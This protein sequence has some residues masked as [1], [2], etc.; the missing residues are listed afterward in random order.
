MSA[1]LGGFQFLK[2]VHQLLVSQCSSGSHQRTCLQLCSPALLEGVLFTED[3]LENTQSMDSWRSH[4]PPQRASGL[5]VWFGP[6]GLS[7]EPC[8][9]LL[10]WAHK[11]RVV[12]LLCCCFV[13][14]FKIFFKVYIHTEKRQK[15]KKH[16]DSIVNIHITATRIKKG[17]IANSWEVS[18]APPPYQRCL[19]LSE[20]IQFVFFCVRLLLPK[21][22]LTRSIHVVAYSHNSLI[23][24]AYS[25]LLC[26]QTASW[27]WTHLLLGR[28]QMLLGT[29]CVYIYS[30]MHIYIHFCWIYSYKWIVGSLATGHWK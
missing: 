4:P 16:V 12:F 14:A 17:N 29:F 1:L 5:T 20:M 6:S 28:S 2:C 19:H 25:I 24:I 27:L 15:T 7:A 10:R 11:T 18:G 22:I 26:E 23:F 9:G 21:V 13:G 30:D 8:W 3:C